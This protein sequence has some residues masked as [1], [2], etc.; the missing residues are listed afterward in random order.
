MRTFVLAI[1]L[2]ATRSAGADKRPPI[3]VTYDAE[4]LDLDKHILQFKPSRPITEATLVAIGEDGKELG[5]NA[6]TYEH[7]PADAW[8]SITWT[9]PADARVM[10]LELRVKA[11][12]GHATNVELIPWSV[13]IDHEDIKFRTDA[14]AIDPDE[15]AKLD[16]SLSKIEDIAK[17]VGSHM[18]L[19]LYIAG[20]TDTVGAA[21]KNRKLSLERA[22]AIGRYFAAK[23]LAIPIVVAGFGEDVLKVKTAD[24][25][26]EPANRRADYVLGPAGGTP[27]FK[28]AYLKVNAKWKPLGR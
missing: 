15:R 7:P 6:A 22:L 28:G 13:T 14:S 20:H 4:H 26:D 1:A 19:T 11:S 24:D 9:Q 16:A 12:D 17:Q 3:H 23:H 10:M 21:A 5:K 2:L 27:P 8:W 25:T 18:K